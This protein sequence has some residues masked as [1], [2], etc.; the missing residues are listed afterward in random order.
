MTMIYNKLWLF[1]LLMVIVGACGGG[2]SRPT[3]TLTSTPT[4]IPAVVTP[5]PT[6]EPGITPS[7]PFSMPS[8]AELNFLTD[9]L[10]SQ[11]DP[12]GEHPIPV[13]PAAAETLQAILGELAGSELLLITHDG[14]PAI[15]N[16]D[17]TTTFTL[18]EVGTLYQLVSLLPSDLSPSSDDL[19]AVPDSWGSQLLPIGGLIV[20]QAMDNVP[21]G[22]YLTLLQASGTF[23]LVN[24]AGVDA[25]RDMVGSDFSELIPPVIDGPWGLRTL[26]EEASEPYS[27]V[28]YQQI[29]FSQNK[30]QACLNLPAPERELAITYAEETI[31]SLT[32]SNL[33]PAEQSFH[34][35]S[36]FGDVQSPA[37]V[38]RCFE[39]LNSAVDQLLEGT[40]PISA[41][42]CLPDFVVTVG[43]P[44]SE[45]DLVAQAFP[46]LGKG[47]VTQAS[48]A[49]A[50]GGVAVIQ[51]FQPISDGEIVDGSG[52]V[53]TLPAGDYR[54]DNFELEDGTEIGRLVGLSG[55]FYIELQAVNIDGEPETDHPEIILDVTVLT[56]C[57][58]NGK[59]AACGDRAKKKVKI[60][61]G[62]CSW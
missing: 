25:F 8:V 10:K 42:E 59:L 17:K 28:T 43:N 51:V 49:T 14:F 45:L 29:C 33:I 19:L 62:P 55:E 47:A 60:C 6:P 48:T 35:E 21:A 40:I 41:T 16:P 20:Y 31:A 34:L 2:S 22:I 32:Q 4:P 1:V 52:A 53:V 18:P 23:Y 39:Q 61:F 46:R 30:Y 36:T 44:F 13:P 26:A 24:L 38:D 12:A 27:F 54:L 50:S 56:Y 57:S 9:R 37:T 5:T 58:K 7:V 15:F 3:S 11:R